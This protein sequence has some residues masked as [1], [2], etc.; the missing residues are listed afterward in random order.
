MY[1]FVYKKPF[2]TIYEHKQKTDYKVHWG[3]NGWMSNKRKQ[4]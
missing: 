1:N 3:D 2:L 4:L